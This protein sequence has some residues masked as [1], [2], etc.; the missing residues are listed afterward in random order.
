ME[1]ELRALGLLSS[2]SDT[3]S[4]EKYLKEL[5][6]RSSENCENK[7]CLFLKYKAYLELSLISTEGYAIDCINDAE[8]ILPKLNNP[9]YEV[10]LCIQKAK[11]LNTISDDKIRKYWSQQ[12]LNILQRRDTAYDKTLYINLAYSFLP[13]IKDFH[14]LDL[15][16]L[17]E[18]CLIAFQQFNANEANC[19]DR[20][21]HIRCCCILSFILQNEYE[22]VKYAN[23]VLMLVDKF[24]CECKEYLLAIR[25]IL[26]SYFSVS[27]AVVSSQE[28]SSTLQLLKDST[29]IGRS[30]WNLLE[31]LHG[32]KCLDGLTQYNADVALLEDLEA[33]LT[34]GLALYCDGNHNEAETLFVEVANS[35]F[36]YISEIAK[37]NLLYMIRRGETKTESSFWTTLEKKKSLSAFDYVNIILY[38]SSTGNKN[39]PHYAKAMEKMVNLTTEETKD[40]TKWWGDASIVGEYESKLVLALIHEKEL[41]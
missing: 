27:S 25:Q 9:K 8:N 35:N 32:L 22:T 24:P 16:A 30:F 41:P 6:A 21:E 1:V 31:W 12:I 40:L 23:D 38:C 19:R 28:K 2:M 5:I 4:E 29:G 18:H 15:A 10:E 37:T 11:L 13:F 7:T 34:N 14:D 3:Q 33:K 39:T 17:K 36:P 26:V 20:L